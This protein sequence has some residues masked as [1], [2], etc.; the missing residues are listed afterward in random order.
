MFATLAMSAGA[1]SFTVVC[2]HPDMCYRLGETATF[3]VTASDRRGRPPK[4]EA[5]VRLDNFGE[6]VFLERKVDLAQEPKFTVSGR[7]EKPGFML[8][9]LT[10]GDRPPTLFSVA[11]EPEKLRPFR[12]CPADFDAFWAEAV[13]K[14]DRDVTAPIQVTEVEPTRPGTALYELAIPATGGRT[15][16]G[17]YSVPTNPPVRP[18]PLS[19]TLPGAGPAVFYENASVRFAN[20]F[21]NVHYYRPV[22][23]MTPKSAEAEAL[24]KVEDDIYAAR[25][26]VSTVRYPHFGLA[27]G[28]EDYFLYGVILA[29]NRAVDWACAQPG[30]DTNRVWYTGQSQG[31]GMGLILTGL[32]R[33]IRR[34]VVKVPALTDHLGFH[35]DG[36]QAGWPGVIAAQLSENRAAAER[37]A[38]Y[39]DALYFA[40]RIHVPI[41]FNVGSIDTVCPPH[42]GYTAYNVCP[43]KDKLIRVGIGQSHTPDKTIARDFS[44]WLWRQ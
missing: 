1:V 10:E 26:P 28:R 14:Y 21:V 7:M 18:M 25:Y 27:A 29:A 31:G 37:N 6:R 44:A 38:P 20:L 9:R 42:A 36:R 19:I 39:F 16:W 43:S 24:Q 34:A 4:G 12:E 33:H 41:R 23:G 17:C 3:T 32:N 15:V 30:I 8:L 2:D 5:A 22:R 11:Y 35:I 13:R 40:Q